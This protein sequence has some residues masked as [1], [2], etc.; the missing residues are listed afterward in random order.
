MPSVG[1]GSALENAWPIR[2]AGAKS[3]SVM[4][5]AWWLQMAVAPAAPRA[6]QIGMVAFLFSRHARAVH[7]MENR[8]RT[9]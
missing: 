5:F 1:D 2:A 8:R 4:P 9:S 3:R 6:V 7:Q